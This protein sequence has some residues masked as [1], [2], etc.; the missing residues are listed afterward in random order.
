MTV[1]PNHVLRFTRRGTRPRTAWPWHP[2]IAAVLMALL[3]FLSGCTV[4]PRGE[5]L[6][7]AAAT[8]AGKPYER[9]FE[10]RQLPV[11]TPNASADDLVRYALLSSAQV[12]QSY[13]EWRAALE[14]IP[15]DGTTKAT[16]A[17]TLTSMLDSGNSSWASN[18]LGIGSDPMADIE[19]PGKLPVAARKALQDARAAGIR[20]EK[21]KFDVRNKVLAAY[22]D[23]ALTAEEL[24]L[25]ETNA[26]LLGMAAKNIEFRIASQGALQQDLLRT[27]NDLEMSKNEIAGMRANLAV[28]L[29]TLNGILNR[30]PDAALVPPAALP[31]TGAIGLKDD[32]ILAKAALY[33]PE[34]RALAQEIAGK[35][36]AIKL[37]KLQ[38]VPDFSINLSSD[39]A[40]VT[41]TFIGSVTVPVAR[42][43]A[44]EA[45]IAQAQAN[46]H[47]A[48]AMRR[49]SGNDLRAQIVIDL[50]MIRDTQ[51]QVDLLQKSIIPRA[52]VIITTLRTSYADGRA[53]LLDALDAQRSLLALGK[54]SAQMQIEHAKRVADLEAIAAIPLHGA[55][56]AGT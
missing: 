56:K 23:Y 4:H 32:E 48:E 20:F 28:Q 45:G 42:Y 39:L 29:A 3:V 8:Q 25:E 43:Q 55:Q 46:L 26:A 51:R 33:N 21:A 7:R 14:Q 5:S 47:A 11:L 44:I 24:R 1:I 34:L 31:P 12:E 16:P 54:L 38:Y 53:S 18:A 6:E 52:Q 17:I 19:G 36:D 50:A 37:A 22:Y 9:P 41:Q 15:Q 10:Q 27:A 40:G 30:A 13:W 49:Q 2:D 35:Q